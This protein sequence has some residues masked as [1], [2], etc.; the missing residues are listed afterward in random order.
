M[1]IHFSPKI[2]RHYNCMDFYCRSIS[3]LVNRD[4]QCIFIKQWDFDFDQEANSIG[5]GIYFY[6][7]NFPITDEKN[8]KLMY[9]HG[10]IV[11]YH[12]TNSS[13][14]VMDN[15]YAYLKYNRPL[16]VRFDGKIMDWGNEIDKTIRRY[17]QMFLVVGINDEYVAYYD[18]HNPSIERRMNIDL[19]KSG[20][21]L[22]YKDKPFK[23]I[24]STFEVHDDPSEHYDFRFLLSESL[25]TT[26]QSIF[27]CNKFESMRSFANKIKTDFFISN[28]IIQDLPIELSPLMERLTLITGSRSRYE[29]FI[30]YLGQKYS[31]N[32]LNKISQCFKELTSQWYEIWCLFLKFMYM[33]EIENKDKMIICDKIIAISD[34]EESLYMK[35]KDMCS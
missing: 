11:K 5:N 21:V 13:E 29:A 14:E 17:K 19:F 15:L 22:Q 35:L 26:S 1:H 16:L 6:N 33:N 25:K 3:E 34:R 7:R 27:S 31:H 8:Y 2:N 10:I 24:Y 28:E 30:S 32:E 23:T 4:Y 9:H 18:T 12:Y 20:C